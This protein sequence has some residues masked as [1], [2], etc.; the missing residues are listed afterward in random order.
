[1]LRAIQQLQKKN[2]KMEDWCLDAGK[3]Y[4][5]KLLSVSN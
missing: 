5:S 4:L 3:A 2:S 1:M